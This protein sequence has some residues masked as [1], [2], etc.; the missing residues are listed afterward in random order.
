MVP[1][2][3]GPTAT[4]IL[5]RY[6]VALHSVV[7]CFPG[8]GGVSQENC[9]TH[10]EKGPVAS[11][12]A[13]CKGSVALQ[14]AFWKESRYRGVLQLHCGRSC[15]RGALSPHVHKYLPSVCKILSPGLEDTVSQF[16]EIS[17]NCRKLP[18]ICRKLL[19]NCRKL[20]AT[21]EF[22]PSHGPPSGLQMQEGYLVILW[23][24]HA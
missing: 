24:E 14:V 10:P 6:S 9:T 13:A 8:F 22:W 23:A 3:H 15:C 2:L 16:P 18:A 5:S 7:R 20:L 17:G 11:T 19:A 12:F 4:V 21:S 1:A